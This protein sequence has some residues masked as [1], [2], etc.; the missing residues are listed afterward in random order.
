MEPAGCLR[1][2]A[3]VARSSL[4]PGLHMVEAMSQLLQVVL[5]PICVLWPPVP[6]YTHTHTHSA[7]TRQ[8]LL[9]HGLPPPNMLRSAAESVG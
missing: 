2:K 4:I 3:F 7:I 1:V 6:P 8:D 9:S 5:I